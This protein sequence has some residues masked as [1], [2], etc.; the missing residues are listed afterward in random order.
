M[1]EGCEPRRQ[2]FAGAPFQA[3]LGGGGP[4]EQFVVISGF[5]A[6]GVARIQLFLG[7]G[8][9]E[10]VS[11]RDNVFVVQAPRA[12]LPAKLV[13]YDTQGRVV[14]ISLFGGT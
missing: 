11:L 5:A 6:D 9:R 1:V 14:G 4:G 7:S 8:A 10:R 2:L 3:G 12:Q 13:F